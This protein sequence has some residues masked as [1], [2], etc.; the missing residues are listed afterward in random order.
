MGSESHVHE[1][2]C[3]FICMLVMSVLANVHLLMSS[4]HH[5]LE[6][7][8]RFRRYSPV[9]FLSPSDGSRAKR[10]LWLLD[11]RVSLISI[12]SGR[13]MCL[14]VSLV[15]SDANQ[16]A[17]FPL[18]PWPPGF[19]VW[20]HGLLL[21]FPLGLSLLSIPAHF[22]PVLTLRYWLFP[23]PNPT[24]KSSFKRGTLAGLLL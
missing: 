6:R 23:S 19:H 13:L 17:T 11:S 14:A 21:S 20:V 4:W 10:S 16:I 22:G 9:Q 2:M 7:A 24:F 1:R 12:G 18:L 3:V 15:L 8:V 5:L